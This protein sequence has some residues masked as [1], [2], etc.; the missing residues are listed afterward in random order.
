MG[1]SFRLASVLKYRQR[2]VDQEGREVALAQQTVAAAQARLRE[3][4]GEIQRHLD[5]TGGQDLRIRDM[6]AKAAWLEYL[7]HER[8]RLQARLAQARLELAKAQ[9]RLNEAWRD[10]EVLKQLESKR[11]GEWVREQE[12]A[13]RKELDEIGQIRAERARRSEIAARGEQLALSGG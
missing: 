1:F 13:A 6:A 12:V 11:R 4:E 9:A 7:G 5:R 10:L 2:I 3:L 8:E